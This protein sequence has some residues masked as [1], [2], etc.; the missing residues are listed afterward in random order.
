MA[1]EKT[2][3]QFNVIL[4]TIVLIL[5]MVFC[6]CLWLFFDHK[7]KVIYQVENGGNIFLFLL[8]MIME[9]LI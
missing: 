4:I 1:S 3:K 5:I 2:S 8:Q 6:I 7:E 9:L